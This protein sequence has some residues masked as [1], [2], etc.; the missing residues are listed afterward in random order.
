MSARLD[1][2]VQFRPMRPA[3]LDRVMAIEP[4]LYSHPWTRGNFQDSI[5]A[6]Y[7][8]RVIECEG[9]I[10]GYGVLMIGA[11]EAHLLNLS[12]ASAWQRRGLGSAL[13]EHFV[14]AARDGAAR[15]MLL[16]VRPSNVAARRLYADFGFRDLS[17][18][19]GYYPAER[20]REDA[21]LMSLPL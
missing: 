19:R 16:E 9:A 7:V 11:G 17:L 10:S 8:C 12:V 2:V 4:T 3:D 15:Q 21:I 20:G 13:L 18:R 1:S 6:G 14:R 5:S